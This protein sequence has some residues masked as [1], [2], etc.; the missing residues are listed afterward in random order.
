MSTRTAS[1]KISSSIATLATQDE[2]GSDDEM[3]L[4]PNA[5][6]DVDITLIDSE[7][8]EGSGEEDEDDEE[9]D[10]DEE[11]E[12]EQEERGK[13]KSKRK[14]RMMTTWLWCLRN[15]N[16]VQRNQRHL[17]R[18]ANEEVQIFTWPTEHAGDDE[19]YNYLVKKALMIQKNPAAKIIIE[20]KETSLA[21]DKENDDEETKKGKKGSKKTRDRALTI[22]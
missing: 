22:F 9:E 10:D 7:E 12:E 6:M 4:D 3:V 18:A 2:L 11:Q 13:T 17:H 21:A 14:R 8:G 19:H 15:A 1:R 20:P 5:N 16:V